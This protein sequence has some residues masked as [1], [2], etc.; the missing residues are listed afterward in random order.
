MTRVILIVAIACIAAAQEIKLHSFD[1]PRTNRAGDAYPSQY[2]GEGGRGTYS[3]DTADGIGGSGLRM[4]LDT[5]RLCVQFNAHNANGTRGFTRDN[6]MGE[7]QYDAYN[8]LEFWIKAPRNAAALTGTGNH[9]YQIGTY[10]KRTNPIDHHS[11]EAGGGHYYHHV[12]IPNNGYWTKVVLNAH[13]HHRRSAASG[14]IEWG[15]LHYPT[16]EAGLNYFD[17][18]TRWYIDASYDRTTSWPKEFGL[19]EI[20]FWR[21]GDSGAIA[22]DS[23]LYSLTTSYGDGRLFLGASA[24][25][26]AVPV[27]HEVRYSRRDIRGNGGWVAAIPAPAGR[28]RPGPGG[29]NG[30]VYQTD[31]IPLAPGDTVWLAIKPE[32]S[33]LYAQVCLPIL[34]SLGRGAASI[35]LPPPPPPADT[36]VTPAEPACAPDTVV[37][38]DTVVQV[39]TAA[40]AAL[41]A[42]QDSLAAS[43]ARLLVVEAER[44]SLAARPPRDTIFQIRLDAIELRGGLR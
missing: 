2:M 30:M 26:A 33:E 27:W 14:S 12:E 22:A 7:W 15:V 41:T 23:L 35:L 29:Y 28:I 37:M 11:D 9:I 1:A 21:D 39:D 8:R 17:L 5:G 3:I 16:G 42:T 44:D 19:D 32:G 36:V 38:R 24:L 34:D 31:S 40:L 4:V 6:A 13:P 10:V 20:R 25:K 43:R 18:L